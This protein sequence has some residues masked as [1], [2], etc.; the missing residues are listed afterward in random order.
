MQSSLQD[1]E[2][3][4]IVVSIRKTTDSNPLSAFDFYKTNLVN[5]YYIRKDSEFCRICCLF[6]YGNIPLIVRNGNEFVINIPKTLG[7]YKE[8][9]LILMEVYDTINSVAKRCDE[10]G[11]SERMKIGKLLRRILFMFV[12]VCLLTGFTVAHKGYELYKNVLNE[13]NINERVEAMKDKD[14]YTHYKDLPSVYINAVV[15]VEDKRFFKHEGIDLIAIGR[16]VLHDI[17]AGRYVEG[18]STITQQLAK[19]MFFNQDKE[20]TRKIAEVLMAFEL[21]KHYTKEQIFEL[22]VNGIYFGDGYYN[23]GEASKGYFNKSPKD[24]TDYE[25]TLLAGV[26]NAPSKYAPTKNLKLAQMRQKKVI[27]RMEAC[28][29]FSSKEAETVAQQIVLIN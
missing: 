27:S 10:K 26:P 21:E 15:S 29:Y 12:T 28:G 13:N 22:Y 20:I 18:G 25:S 6:F 3:D 1:Q 11:G 17:Q 8:L 7:K 16:A 5:L 4:G 19:N 2:R 24:M 14:E 9:F 23:V